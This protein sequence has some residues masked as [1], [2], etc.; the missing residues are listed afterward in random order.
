MPL[1]TS[2]PCHSGASSDVPREDD[3]GNVPPSVMVSSSCFDVLK[4]FGLVILL[5]LYPSTCSWASKKQEVSENDLV[6]PRRSTRFQEPPWIPLEGDFVGPKH[7]S[8]P[9]VGESSSSRGEN[10]RKLHEKIKMLKASRA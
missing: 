1:V 9:L 2:S 4:S 10:K 6:A 5:R 8:N 7:G 3:M